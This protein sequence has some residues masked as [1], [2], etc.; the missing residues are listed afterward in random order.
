MAIGGGLGLGLSLTGTAPAAGLSPPE[1]FAFVTQDGE[2]VTQDGE[3]VY[4]PE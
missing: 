2:I 1:G 3:P 4:V